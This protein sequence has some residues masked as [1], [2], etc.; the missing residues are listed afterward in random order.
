MEQTDGPTIV[1]VN[2]VV[3]NLLTSSS[4]IC[5]CVETCLRPARMYNALSGLGK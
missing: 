3:T 5:N 1:F 4:L 2:T